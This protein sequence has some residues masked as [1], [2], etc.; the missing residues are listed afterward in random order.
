MAC[1]MWMKRLTWTG[2]PALWRL[3]AGG[4]AFTWAFGACAE[5][6]PGPPATPTNPPTIPLPVARAPT[7]A[8]AVGLH[9]VALGELGGWI[10]IDVELGGISSRWL[11]DTGASRHFI[12]PALA[13]RLG[14][15]AGARRR[16]QLPLGQLDGHEVDLPALRVGPIERAGQ[17]A[18]VA[19][20]DKVFGPAAAALDGVLGVPLLE[21]AGLLLDL[22]AGAATWLPV[23]A[24]A[25][26]AGLVPVP[27]RRHRGLPVVP[28]QMSPA[29]GA[30]MDLVLDTGNPAGVVRVAATGLPPAAALAVAPGQQL[31]VLP[32]LSVGPH[33]RHDVP[34][35]WLVAPALAAEL[36]GGSIQGLLGM[37]WLDGARWQLDLAQDRLCVEAAQ[38]ATPGGFGLTLQRQGEG[39]AIG[40]VLAGSPAERAGLRSGETIHRWA[41][42]PASR[43][44]TD[45]WQAV[46]GADR[47]ELEAGTPPRV[48][49][50]ERAI[51]APRADAP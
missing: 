16:V 22:R 4:L 37:A 30:A 39:L 47:V 49:R 36:A 7:G 10:A 41:G 9:R 3:T 31:R 18:V 14:L 1:R 19:E 43:H 26:L 38:R 24:S 8:A 35:L 23:D 51:F 46:Q 12:A 13:Q 45:L 27:L 50:L 21:T 34:Q 40:V 5:A 29:D 6:Q 42:L 11:L 28:A 15:S 2:R 17:T 48:L 25:C 32:R 44:L 33:E 20:L